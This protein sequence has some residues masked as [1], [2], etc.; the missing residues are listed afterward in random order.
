MLIEERD[1]EDAV[2]TIYIQMR[3]QQRGRIEEDPSLDR[4]VDCLVCPHFFDGFAS[5]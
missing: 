5:G 4:F 3:M 1:N 2:S